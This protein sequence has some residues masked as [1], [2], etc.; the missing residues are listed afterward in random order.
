[1]LLILQFC[2]SM[3]TLRQTLKDTNEER[4][5]LYPVIMPLVIPSVNEV[6]LCTS[7]DVSN[8]DKTSFWIRGFEPKVQNRI[9]H[10]MAL[11]GCYENFGRKQITPTCWLQTQ[12]TNNR[13]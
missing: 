9:V 13:F 10:H 4:L 7:V 6:Y 3:T 5:F 12:R 2:Q 8:D 1:M 11:A